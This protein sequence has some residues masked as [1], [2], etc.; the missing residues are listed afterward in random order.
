MIYSAVSVIADLANDYL[1]SRF[2]QSEEKVII[3]NI[4]NPDGSMAVTEPDKMIL[5]LVN[6]Q[7][8]T[9]NQKNYNGSTNRPVN[10]N[11]YLLFSAS[12]NDGNYAEG[13]RYLSA[14]ISFFQS[15]KVMNHR[16]TPELSDGID[17]L[18]FEIVN[19]DL[20]NQSHL[21]GTI[22][23]KYLP[24]ILYKVRMVTFQEGVLTG[25]DVPFSGFGSNF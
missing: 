10:M 24:S 20:Q 3:S 5:T 16:N 19:Q 21:W 14:I 13:L 11:L 1:S 6:L 17:K 23:G 15:H 2:G 25:N 9:V 4:V 8:E 12:F 18:T 22:G 7:Q